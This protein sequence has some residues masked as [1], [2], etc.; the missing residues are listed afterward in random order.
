VKNY[1]PHHYLALIPSKLLGR[2]FYVPISG[3]RMLISY[4]RYDTLSAHN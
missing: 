3:V 1:K 4:M 2:L